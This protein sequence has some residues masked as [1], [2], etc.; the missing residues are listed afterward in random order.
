MTDSPE[1]P[2]VKTTAGAPVLDFLGG[3]VLRRFKDAGVMIFEDV[4]S[5]ERVAALHGAYTTGYVDDHQDRI[6]TMH[7]L[8]G[9]SGR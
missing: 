4:I 5:P 8:S 6:P 7:C 3:E 1:I 2:R 9:T